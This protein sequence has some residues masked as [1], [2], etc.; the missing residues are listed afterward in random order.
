MTSG[1]AHV[2]GGIMAAYIAFGARRGTSADSGHH[3]RAGNSADLENARSRKQKSP[4]PMGTVQMPKGGAGI[5]FPR[6][7]RARDRLKGC[8][9]AVNVGRY[10]DCVPGAVW[11]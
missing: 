1:M 2:S 6:C 10:A 3:D 9:M 8:G 4:K 11:H 7:D 5:K